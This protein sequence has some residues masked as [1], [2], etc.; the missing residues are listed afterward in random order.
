VRTVPRLADQ[1]RYPSEKPLPDSAPLASIGVAYADR[2]V[3]VIGW[4]VPWIAAYIALSFAFAL[5]LKKP[6][7]VTL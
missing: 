4:Q 1:L 3:D 5:A 2:P 6:L 7:G